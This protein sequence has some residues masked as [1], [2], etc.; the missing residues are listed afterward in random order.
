MVIGPWNCL[1]QSVVSACLNCLRNIWAYGLKKKKK[2]FLAS[3]R[4][5]EGGC[6]N[7]H[8]HRCTCSL[9][10]NSKMNLGDCRGICD[11]QPPSPSQGGSGEV[12]RGSRC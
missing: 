10:M 5:S 4:D 6:R 7:L 12:K 8:M 1:Y 2:R 3:P 9:R 11:E